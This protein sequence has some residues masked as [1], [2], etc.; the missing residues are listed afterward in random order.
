MIPRVVVIQPSLAKYR[1]PFYASLAQTNVKLNVVYGRSKDI[2]NNESQRFRNRFS[3]VRGFSFYGARFL[4]HQAQIVCARKALADVLVLSWD[5]HYLSLMPALL[6]ARLRGVRTLLWGHGYSKAESAMRLLIRRFVGRFADGMVF[7][8]KR[9]ASKY[10]EDFGWSTDR[11]F[12]AQNALSQAEIAQEVCD[13]SKKESQ[14]AQFR[15][16]AGIHDCYTILFCSRLDDCNGVDLLLRA[17][18]GLVNQQIKT[19]LVIIGEGSSVVDLKQLCRYLEIEDRVIFLGGVYDETELAPWFLTADVFCYPENIGLSILHAFGY[20]LPV[21]TSDDIKSHNPEIAALV[22]EENGLLYKA[23]DYQS[24]CKV[25]MRIQQNESLRDRMSAAA[26][27]T[28]SEDFNL[29][30]MVQGF[31]CAIDSVRKTQ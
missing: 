23:H 2:P 9:T 11:V 30:T 27:R 16:D 6:L 31:F 15:R 19:R 24:L 22:P 20:G 21:V 25:L 13:W 3:P 18:K 14:L 10:V 28:V 8:D 5:S 29:E 26:I 12:V 4:W 1:E 7:Y 17:V